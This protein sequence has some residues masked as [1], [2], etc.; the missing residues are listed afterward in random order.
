MAILEF[1]VKSIGNNKEID[2]KLRECAF[3]F[4]EDLVVHKP[5]LF[6]NADILHPLL[7]ICF[8][9]GAEDEAA[10]PQGENTSHDMAMRL[11]DVLS[12]KLANKVIYSPVMNRAYAC[13]Q[14][15]SEFV[16]KAGLMA[17]AACSQGTSDAMKNDLKSICEVTLQGV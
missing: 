13:M 4:V 3:D 2:L 1:A 6:R 5:D 12:I 10:Y 17:V 8:E 11:L 15:E 7:D 14:H 16:K 9:I